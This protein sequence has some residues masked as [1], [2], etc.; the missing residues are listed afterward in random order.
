MSTSKVEE[1]IIDNVKAISHL[2]AQLGGYSAFVIGK[3]GG[4]KS[5]FISFLIKRLQGIKPSVILKEG[6]E[7]GYAFMKLT[8][9]ETFEWKINPERKGDL[10]EIKFTTKDGIKVPVTTAIAERFF[11]VNFNVDKFIRSRPQEQQKELEKISGIDLDDVNIRYKEQFELRTA[12]KKQLKTQEAVLKPVNIDLPKEELPTLT[13]QEE[14]AS[15]DLHNHKYDT[16]KQ[17]VTDLE[18]QLV[19]DNT[20]IKRLETMLATANANKKKTET[21][22]T[23]GKKWLEV[24]KNKRKGDE[25]LQS[26]QKSLTDTIDK[27]LKI[28]ENNKA[29][30]AKT[31]F[32]KFKKEVDEVEAKVKAIEDEK[33]KLIKTA[34]LPEGFAFA[35]EGEGILYNGFPFESEQQ[36][37][38]SLYIAA[39]KLSLLSLGEVKMIHFEGSALDPDNMAEVVK[40]ADEQDLQVVIELP[41]SGDVTYQIIDNTVTKN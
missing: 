28:V 11:P 41:K 4:G 1:I 34:K 5:T 40:W 9:G 6:T 24:D 19:S 35:V 23:E 36:A 18:K 30:E 31:A 33:S 2:D 22:I 29:I 21:R 12:K 17:G 37:L 16:A 10:S 26:L 27:N 25:A 15:I 7:N 32:D 8:T 38:S 3:N 20:E 13:I 39:L 14:I